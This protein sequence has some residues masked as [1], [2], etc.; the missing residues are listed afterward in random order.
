M[1]SL[2]YKIG[3]IEKKHQSAINKTPSEIREDKLKELYIKLL[4]AREKYR[5]APLSVETAEKEYYTYKDTPSGYELRQ[6]NKYK[7][8]AKDLKKEK[9]KEHD[10]KIKYVLESLAYHDSQRIYITNV[11]MIK[12][13]LLQ[14]ILDKLKSIQNGSTNKSTNYRKT[15]YLLQEQEYMTLWIQ[16]LNHCI[17]AF[18]I[19]YVIFCLKEEKMSTF[20]YVFATGLLLIVFY[21]DWGIQL[22]RSI[23]LS[24]N[25]YTAWGA[26]EEQSTFLF[27]VILGISSVLFFIIYKNR[28]ND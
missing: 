17:T 22:I 12:L 9:I 26:E 5:S 10:E 8:E 4:E 18:A 6:L 19:V 28:Q 13:T 21:L 14:E 2:D 15:F 20:T 11:N 25:I 16:F 23:P 24:F 1:D 27:W 7:E 3:Q